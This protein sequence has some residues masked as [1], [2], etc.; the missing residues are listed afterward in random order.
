M[1]DNKLATMNYNIGNVINYIVTSY[2]VLIVVVVFVFYI[3][4]RK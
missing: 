1:D 3:I 4:K 2:G